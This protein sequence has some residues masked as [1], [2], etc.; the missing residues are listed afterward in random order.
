MNRYKVLK[1]LGDGT[2]G[3]VWKAHNLETNEAV[4]IKKMKRKF[5]SWEECITLREVKSLRKLKHPTIIKLKEVIRENNELFFVFEYMDCNLYQLIKD[6][7]KPL[8]EARIRSIIYQIFQGLA[9][10]HK[11]GYF[12]RDIKPENV[13]VLKDVIK[14][15]D[16]GLARE[17]RSA[18]PYTEYVSTRWYRAP[19]VI[20][21]SPMYDAAVD[22]F[23][24]GAIMA[25]LFTS[26][27]LFPG[28][29]EIDQVYKVCAVLGCPT[30]DSW[31][32][33]LDRAGQLGWSF[34]QFAPTPLAQL[35]PNASVE[36]ISLMTALCQ[37]DPARR[38][39]ATQ[40]LAHPF[41][42]ELAW[43]SGKLHVHEA[44][45]E[46]PSTFAN[47]M[48]QPPLPPLHTSRTERS[49]FEGSSSLLGAELENRSAASDAWLLAA[50]HNN[51]AEASDV[52]GP[53]PMDITLS[54]PL[55]DQGP[56]RTDS[57][58]STHST[59]M[60]REEQARQA[61]S[62]LHRQQLLLQQQ[63]QQQ[64][65]QQHKQQQQQQSWQQ[66][67]HHP[68][69]AHGTRKEGWDQSGGEDRRMSGAS[70]S[71]SAAASP[72]VPPNFQTERVMPQ[73]SGPVLDVPHA[74]QQPLGTV[75]I[76]YGAGNSLKGLHRSSLMPQRA[77]KAAAAAAAP[78]APSIS[79][80][81][82]GSQAGGQ[83]SPMDI[84]PGA[85]SDASSKRGGNAAANMPSL[86]AGRLGLGLGL[87]PT[88]NTGQS[89]GPPSAV[90][91]GSLGPLQNMPGPRNAQQPHLQPQVVSPYQQWLGPGPPR[92][93]L[94][95]SSASSS[96]SSRYRGSNLD[97]QKPYG[98]GRI[99]HR[100][101]LPLSYQLQPPRQR[102]G[103][104]KGD[105]F[106]RKGSDAEKLLV[107]RPA[108]VM[109]KHGQKEV[110]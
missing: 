19:E 44:L 61:A 67:H 74:Q 76:P 31:P 55:A 16:F 42:Q 24:V 72:R 9:Y 63:L 92:Q 43:P 58:A 109:Q 40:A 97:Q 38:P 28:Q 50:A 6:R 39:T 77:A 47:A 54:D 12:H 4:A 23:A 106:W 78:P 22:M 49:S 104:L 59:V 82:L 34:P 51:G 13:L 93:M 73:A 108:W 29:S 99:D 36:A 91:Q 27:P 37:W 81:S 100:T 46:R 85:T 69:N 30:P 8:S 101:G 33:G 88:A 48:P 57:A 1:I 32:E 17:V 7:P 64:Q 89:S 107:S 10:M 70:I 14:I 102:E 56:S 25:E 96:R 86:Q 66:Q 60:L 26:R 94:H 15:A 45:K 52:Q 68:P 71:S 20:L 79:A 18:P 84:G 21:R 103:S 87:K 41:F 3:S 83:S 53:E 62:E 98:G 90:R 5:Y 80:A 110:A 35:V 65:I 105:P 2:Y 95:Q 11:H 75:S